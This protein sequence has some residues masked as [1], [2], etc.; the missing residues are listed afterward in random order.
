M[1]LLIK[2]EKLL[3][4]FLTAGPAPS[5]AASRCRQVWLL[6][7]II[8]YFPFFHFNFKIQLQRL[9]MED[10]NLIHYHD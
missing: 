10:Q 6:Q 3:E 1:T 9:K 8:K 5:I 7:K 2:D 4:S